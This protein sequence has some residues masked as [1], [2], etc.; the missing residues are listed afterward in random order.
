MAELAVTVTVVPGPFAGG[1]TVID[2]GVLNEGGASAGA[3]PQ[4]ASGVA[5]RAY[6]RLPPRLTNEEGSQGRVLV[7]PLT[8]RCWTYIVLA[9]A[10]G[11][12]MVMV[13]PLPRWMTMGGTSGLAS[14][15]DP[16]LGT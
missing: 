7:C 3:E 8:A 11:A 10:P 6:C 1:V 14:T 5:A 13:T 9:S 16:W 2:G 4:V 12:S 15:S